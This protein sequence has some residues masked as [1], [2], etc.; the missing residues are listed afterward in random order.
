MQ[1]VEAISWLEGHGLA[2]NDLVVMAE[3]MMSTISEG[4]V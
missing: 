3:A 2:W 4:E 1:T